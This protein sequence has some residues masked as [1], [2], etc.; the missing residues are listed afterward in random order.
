M[1]QY[2]P[3]R[4]IYPKRSPAPPPRR[5]SGFRRK[6]V[7][8]PSPADS[9]GGSSGFW[10]VALSSTVRPSLVA[11]GFIAAA[12]VF[13]TYAA[14]HLTNAF[15]NGAQLWPG[16]GLLAGLLLVA[17]RQHRSWYAGTYF[18]S[19]GIVYWLCGHVPGDALLRVAIAISEGLVLASLLGGNRAWVD[20][21]EDRLVSWAKFIAAG[22]I[23][24]PLLG[25]L[26]GGWLIG[27]DQGIDFPSGFRIWYT[28]H[29]MSMC[30]MV[31]LLLR[32]RGRQINQLIAQK[33]ALE[34][35]IWLLTLAAVAGIIF[36]QNLAL[37]LFLLIPLLIMIVF[38]ARFVGLVLGVGVLALLATF[39]LYAS[40]GPF[41]A[42]ASGTKWWG[43]SSLSQLF[44]MIIFGTMV[45][46]A[47]LLEER[48]ARETALRAR[49]I[50]LTRMA[51]TDALTDIPNRRWFD[52]K[53]AA[54]LTKASEQSQ[55]VAL[56]VIDIDYFKPYNDLYGH[57]A[58]DACLRSVAAILQRETR[59]GDQLC[60]RYGGEEFVVILPGVSA[61]EAC[62]VGN[63]L[64]LAVQNAA[65]SHAASSFGVVTVSIGAAAIRPDTRESGEL[66]R[67]SD[68]ALYQAKQLGRNRTFS[69]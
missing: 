44:V 16:P 31:P 66:F 64:C 28:A 36:A 47:A 37:P 59:H 33:R 57:A 14:I 49:N 54:A 43:A 62:L 18:L 30:V 69:A 17:P 10:P 67:L 65:I 41:L 53:M 6:E 46:I 4:C 11:L 58:G 7:G 22:L 39:T 63:R 1:R 25:A 60:A 48:R 56:L 32:L 45:L 9:R 40:R 35:L 5:P 2:D 12:F 19:A 8:G 42:M 20:G 13:S 68:S 34:T 50:E 38:R 21:H 15:A 29:A 23:F 51:T 3:C 55:S 52:T 26:P 24:I 27:I 61:G